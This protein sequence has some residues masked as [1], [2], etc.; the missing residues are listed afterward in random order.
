MCAC[1]CVCVC[2]LL[3]DLIL[4]C[5]VLIMVM[6][7]V[8]S[9][10]TSRSMINRCVNPKRR[11]SSRAC[12][13]TIA[14]AHFEEREVMG[15]G[16]REAGT[17]YAACVFYFSQ[18]VSPLHHHP[19]SFVLFRHIYVCV[20]IYIYS[21]GIYMCFRHVYRLSCECHSQRMSFAH[22]HTQSLHHSHVDQLRRPGPVP[23]LLARDSHSATARCQ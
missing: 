19:F 13:Y 4:L 16:G 23:P 10:L 12:M 11:G 18:P 1:V 3:H 6:K 9:I 21:L 20:Y 15:L 17:L 14:F 2:R 22:I 8:C 7:L 5:G